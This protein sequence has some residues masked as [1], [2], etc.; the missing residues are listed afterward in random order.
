MEIKDITGLSEP[1]KKLIEVIFTGI[2]AIG[3][4]YIIKKTADAKAYEMK[5]I[6][7]TIQGNQFDKCSIIYDNGKLIISSLDVEMMKSEPSLL[8]R[9]ENRIKYIE[10]RKQKNIESITQKA[11]EQLSNETEVSNEP[12]DEDW[13]TR[14]F[15]YAEEI[16]NEEMQ[17][18][19][20]QILAGEVKRPKSYSLRTLQLLRNLSKEEAHIFSKVANY[21]I[22][23]RGLACLYKGEKKDVLIEYNISN[24]DVV[25]LQDIDIL[26]SGNFTVYCMEKSPQ[27]S[28][29]KGIIGDKV[30]IIEKTPNSPELSIP[31]ILFT[32]LGKE[33][34]SLVERKPEF[35]Y[36]QK[37][38]S[39]LRSNNTSVMYADIIEK[40]QDGFVKHV[41]PVKDIPEV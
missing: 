1:L 10:Q 39:D 41:K 28:T 9:A 29:L 15:G 21:S 36:I 26:H 22:E 32:S 20:A 4:P 23:I 14:F 19:W 11:A 5:V 2:G 40:T 12:V 24:H 35:K 8:E 17:N 38:A 37:I 6:S 34:L 3:K 33:L 13:I 7:D 25:I 31:V 18:L 30:L 27:V 16:S